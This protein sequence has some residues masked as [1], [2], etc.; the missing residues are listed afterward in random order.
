MLKTKF[1]IVFTAVLMS[2]C[3]NMMETMFFHFKLSDGLAKEIAQSNAGVNFC[4]S[5][6]SIDKNLAYAF[7]N[8]S[9]Q[10]LDITV[11][12]RALYK[13]RYEQF[14]GELERR[15]QVVTDC[16]GLNANLP[17]MIESL[18]GSYS[19]IANQLRIGRAQ[20]QQQMTLMMSNYG[21]N[22]TQQ[23]YAMTYSWPRVSYVEKQSEPTNYL[24]NTSKG[25]VQC[26]T[27]NKNYVFCM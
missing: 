25:L 24:V 12:D 22:W 7:S 6:D 10:V 16:A 26:R 17:R 4:L 1:I 3:A 11:L 13:E 18:M 15:D 21:S 27:T 23:N 20:E 2:G 9:A 5:R 19:N 8:V 14:M